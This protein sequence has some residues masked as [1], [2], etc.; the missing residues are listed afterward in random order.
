MKTLWLTLIFFVLFSGC[1]DKNA[2]EKFHMSEKEEL[3]ADAI[4]NSKVKNAQEVNGIVSVVYLNRVYPKN[5]PDNEVFYVNFY[6]KN[7]SKD[8]SFWLNGEKSI[9]TQEL[10]RD[11]FYAYLTPLKTKWSKYYLVKF[12]KQKDIL[13]FSLHNDSFSSNPLVFEKDE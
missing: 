11:N 5:F 2:F 3:G 6:L 9:F 10:K 8:F 1:A 4:L 13:S 7:K 12:K